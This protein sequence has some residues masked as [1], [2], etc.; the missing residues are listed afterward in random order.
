MKN[1][2]ALIGASFII[3]GILSARFLAI[4]WTVFSAF[5]ILFLV[6][7]SFEMFFNR[8]L[9]G[10]DS[11]RSFTFLALLFFTSATS[12]SINEQLRDN[13][14]ITHYLNSTDTLTIYCKVVDEPR[15]HEGRTKLLVSLISL[16]NEFDSVEVDGKAYVNITADKRKK[17]SPKEIQ[18]GSYISFNSIIQSP[19]DER[20][21]GEFSYRQYLELNNIYATASVYGYSNVTVSDHRE[22]NFFFESIIFPS[23]NFVVKTIRTVMKG[24]EANFLIGLLLGDRTEIS[25]EIKSAF[26]NTGTIHVLAVSGSHVVLVAEIIFVVVGLLRFSQKPKILIAIAV[27]IYYM[28]L[29]GATPS[30]VR[31]TLMIIIFYLGKLFQERTDIYNVLGV[32]AIIILLIEPKQLFDVGFQLS[33]SAVFSIVYFYPKLNALIPKIPEPLEEF[34]I[35]KWLWQL[36]AVS[37]AAQIGTLPFTAFYFGKVSIVSL[38]AN[39]IVVPIVGLIV[40]IGLG[41]AILGIF[42]LWIA[43]CFSEVNDLLAIFTLNFVKWA[44]QVPFAIVNTATF[45]IQETLLYSAFIGFLFNIGNRVIHKRIIFASLIFANVLLF[46]SLLQPSG[47]YLRITFLDVGQGDGAVIQFPSGEVVVVDAGPRTNEFDAGE[48]NVAPYLRKN[49]ISTIDAIIITHPDAD[50]LGGVPYLLKN[51]IVKKTIDAD[52]YAQSN[53]FYEYNYLRKK[54]EHTTGKAGMLIPVGNAR[55]YILHPTKQFI[56]ADS[57]NGFSGLNESSIVFKL[58]Y[59]ETSFLFS[60]DAETEA[61]EHMVYSFRDFLDSDVLKAGHHGSLTSSSEKYISSVKPQEVIVS[62]AK[63]NKFRHPSK[64]VIERFKSFGAT[65]YRTDVE[66]AI[67]LES[68]GVSVNKLK[69]RNQRMR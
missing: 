53:L 22:G 45:G 16:S 3:S 68:D 66:G 39:L 41:G 64:L 23:K 31:A 65:V 49:G 34:K 5:A 8:A 57:S 9:M 47:K 36:F 33:F 20:N 44:E 55:L 27:L 46:D 40:T 58:Q 69:W 2:P 59:G 11:I 50:H 25:E 18:Y 1:R 26:M 63:F 19:S 60:G 67:I 28:F 35:M 17:E 51:F 52:Q 24:D 30:V 32:S 14:H 12:Y 15:V 42:S 13:H 29:T 37:L 10:R 61:E 6:I 38:F 48:K 4:D 62:V 56:D 43:S 7:S 21:P 54:N